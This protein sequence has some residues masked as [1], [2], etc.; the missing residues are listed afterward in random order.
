[1]NIFFAFVLSFIIFCFWSLSGFSGH[2][3]III[4][5]VSFMILWK[6]LNKYEEHLISNP[7]CSCIALKKYPLF[8]KLRIHFTDCSWVDQTDSI[9]IRHYLKQVGYKLKCN[10]CANEV[11]VKSAGEILYLTRRSWNGCKILN[12]IDE[13]RKL[14]VKENDKQENEINPHFKIEKTTK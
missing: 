4:F 5:L 2:H 14:W 12:E 9:N 10:R 7:D 1:M 8:I 13:A 3:E 6:L 11:D